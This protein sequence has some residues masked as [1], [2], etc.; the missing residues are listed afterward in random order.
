MFSNALLLSL[1]SF[2]EIG[3]EDFRTSI[4]SSF[5][6]NSLEHSNHLTPTASIV[7]TAKQSISISQSG[8]Y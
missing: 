1:F 2:A 4:P 8:G 3:A 7:T 5:G 6:S